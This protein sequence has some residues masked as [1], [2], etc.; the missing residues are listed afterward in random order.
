[1]QLVLIAVTLVTLF[2]SSHSALV[3]T[4]YE[5][6]IAPLSLTFGP[7]HRLHLEQLPL[8]LTLSHPTHS[9]LEPL[10]RH[11]PRE[12]DA[13]NSI[14]HVLQSRSIE[15]VQSCAIHSDSIAETYVGTTCG[16]RLSSDLALQ[17]EMQLHGMSQQLL[18]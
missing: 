11:T 1:M 9:V 2:A 17:S 3:I 16:F 18:R 10:E 5:G 4:F 13:F 6:T 12:E 8:L 15:Y 14:I 7:P